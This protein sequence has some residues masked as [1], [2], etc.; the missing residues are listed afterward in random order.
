MNSG[1]ASTKLGFCDGEGSRAKRAPAKESQLYRDGVWLI[2]GCANGVEMELGSREENAGDVSAVGY[3][4]WSEEGPR[5]REM[6]RVRL[7]QFLH[8]SPGGNKQRKYWRQPLQQR[9]PF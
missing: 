6:S 5:F 3:W 7:Y 9:Y 2:V 4:Q 1:G 8:T